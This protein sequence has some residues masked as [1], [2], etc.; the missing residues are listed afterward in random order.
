MKFRRTI[1]KTF[2]SPKV[3]SIQMHPTRAIG[4]VGL[5]TGYIQVWDTDK[6]SVV[7]TIQVS[8][9]PIRTCAIVERMDWVV[10]GSDDGNIS[11]YELGKYRKV[12]SFHAHDD[13]IRKIEGH[14][15]SAGFIT[16]CDDTTLKMWTYENDICHSMTYSGHGHFVMDVCF[17]PNDNNKFISCS[18]DSTIKVWSVKQPHCIK[19]FKGH[20]SGINSICFLRNTQYLVSGAD[21]LTV[22][23]WDFQTTQCIVTLSGHTNNVSR[24]YEMD[25]FPLFASCSE[26]GTVRL[27][28]SRSFKQEDFI[29]LEGG[30]VWDIKDKDGR[31]VVGCD[32][33]LVFIGVHQASSLV[34]MSRNRIF[35]TV[36]DVVFGTKT[37]N[38]GVVKELSTLGFY[39]SELCVSPSGKIVAVG[40]EN[41]FRI[42]SSL[43]FRNKFNGEGRDIHFI[44]DDE[45]VA[46]NGDVVSFYRKTDV[47]RSVTIPRMTRLFYLGADLIGCNTCGHTRIYSL[48]SQ[49]VFHID[50]PSDHLFVVKDLLVSCG[51]VMQI[52]RMDQ[53]VIAG[54]IEQEIEV[55]EEGIIDG[56]KHLCTEHYTVSS[57]VVQ[58]DI[59]YFASG[60]KAY[61][62]ILGDVPYVYQ[63][64]TI[65]GTFAGVFE[66]RVFYVHEKVVE[67]KKI[68]TEFLGFQ[69]AVLLGQE[70]TVSDAIRSKA[71]VFFESLDMHEEAL[72]L[73]SDDNQRFEILLKL[74]RYDEAFE[75][76]NS[77]INYDK[78]G[79]CFLGNNE[80]ARASECFL[81]SKNWTS[82]LLADVLSEKRHLRSIGAECVR[83]GRMNCALAAY[84]KCGE[85]EECA[86]LL[87]NTP[88]HSLFVKNYLGQ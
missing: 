43:G 28:N 61:Y 54:F 57:Y 3:K 72:G 48:S 81:R 9:E 62:A 51:A 13:Y 25:S 44:T 88:F 78:L 38:I 34:T 56:F 37:D 22:K 27:W 50:T 70:Y 68:D 17:Y 71:I 40:N 80:L 47:V 65:N 66:D 30:R 85:Y 77:I 73:C 14:P 21:D 53:D 45:F 79:R 23:V 63:F 49:F 82:L 7:E 16:A 18:L 39:P 36:S 5:F 64:C 55:G 84:L 60:T 12:K 59:L 31:I 15:Q 26:D 19:T 67:S 20:T 24:V 29:A 87:E 75:R 74:G 4:I 32:E 83:E 35:Y 69:R 58:D 46:R 42:Y 1:E 33:D 11:I 6:M 8:K 76:A 52:Y 41:E 10:V 2:G 86:R